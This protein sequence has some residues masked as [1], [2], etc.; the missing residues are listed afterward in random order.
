M[1]D[2][3]ENYDLQGD[4]DWGWTS[5][6]HIVDT[7]FQ[8]IWLKNKIKNHIEDFQWGIISWEEIGFPNPDTKCDGVSC[9]R[10]TYYLSQ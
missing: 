9:S 6:E 4:F 1:V 3:I 8:L 5:L 2:A 10:V 7:T